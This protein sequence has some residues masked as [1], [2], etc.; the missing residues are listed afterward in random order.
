MNRHDRPSR[1]DRA[2]AFEETMQS[3]AIDAR[4]KAE[5][6]KA[7][8]AKARKILSKRWVDYCSLLVIGTGISLLIDKLV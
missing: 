5:E 2:A 8:A 1:A 6:A 3:L 4:Q 7:E